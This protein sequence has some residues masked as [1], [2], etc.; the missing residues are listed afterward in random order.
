MINLHKVNMRRSISQG[1]T[2]QSQTYD[3]DINNQSNEKFKTEQKR[4]LFPNNK[5]F[6]NGNQDYY[7]DIT[8]DKISLI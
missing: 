8:K 5:N 4:I 1:E 6:F 7:D 2:K 3:L